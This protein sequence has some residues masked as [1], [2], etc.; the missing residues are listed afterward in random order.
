MDK[1]TTIGLALAKSVFL[2][3]AITEEGRVAVCRA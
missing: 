2:I 3:H 1:I